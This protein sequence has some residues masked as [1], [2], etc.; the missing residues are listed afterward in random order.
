MK[1]IGFIWSNTKLIGRFAFVFRAPSFFALSF[2]IVLHHADHQLQLSYLDYISIAVILLLP[3]IYFIHYYYSPKKKL[4]YIIHC[5]YDLFVVGWAIG[6]LI[7]SIVPSFFMMLAVLSN[8]IAIRGFKKA[9]FFLLVPLGAFL[10]LWIGQMEI[11][12]DY[13]DRMLYWFLA[14]TVVHF[15]IL[16]YIS[17][18]YVIVYLKMNKQLRAQSKE[19]SEQREEIQQQAEE[20]KSLNDSLGKLNNSLE[21]N[22]RE[23]TKELIEKNNKLSQYAF[24]NAHKLRAPLARLLGLLQLNKYPN[25]VEDERERILELIEESAEELDSIIST[26][27]KNLE[28]DEKSSQSIE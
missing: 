20:L 2:F 8:H 28:D 23:R 16:S 3:F 21:L 24:L 9:Y 12:L 10:A 6:L 22:V 13:S 7:L 15:T 1:G 25:E 5:S 11:V 26:I 19:I 17:N 18:Y 14:Y 27:N 4:L